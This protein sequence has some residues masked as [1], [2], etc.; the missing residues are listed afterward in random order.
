MEKK[1]KPAP[2]VSPGD[3][4][5]L[6]HNDA[7]FRKLIENSYA[8]ITLLSKDFK[9]IYRSRSAER[10]SGWSN[11]ERL[12]T[13]M[14]DLTHPDDRKMLNRHLKQSLA[15]PGAAIHCTYRSKHYNGHYIWLECS[16]T[17]M[18]NEQDVNAIVFNYHDVT[19][20]K[21]YEEK[22]Q[23]SVKELSAYKY[24]LDESAIVAITD[25]KGIIKHVNDNFCKISKYDR[26]ELLGQDH[27][28]INSSYHNK[29]FIKNIWTTIANG[30]TWKGELKNKAKDGSYYW[31][32]TT[33]VPF[34]NDQGKPYEYI[35]IRSDITERKLNQEK[36][37]EHS[38]FISTITDNIPA[39]IAYWTLDLHCLFAN[40]AL[41]DWFEMRPEEMLGIHKQALMTDNE[42]ETYAPY[43]AN[44]LH[45][46][47]QS[48]ERTFTKASGRKT[49]THTQY[50]PDKDANGDVKGFYSVIY[51]ITEVKLAELEIKKQTEQVEYLLESITDGFIGLNKN[52]CYT[53]ANKEVGKILGVD[54]DTLIG[55]YI[56]DVFPDAIGSATYNAI[57]KAFTERVYVSNEDFYEPLNLWQ[58]NRIYPTGEG[59]S[60]FIRDITKKKQ[61]EQHLKLLE[62]VIT[63]A[64]D[65]VIITEAHPLD[66]PGPR[67][68]Y[69]NDAFTKMTNYSFE[70]VNGE[71]PRILQGPKSDENELKRLSHAIRNNEHCEVTTVNYKKTGEEF[72]INFSVSP[73]KNQQGKTTHYISIE[74]D[75]TEIKNEA[76]QKAQL[77]EAVT[78]SLQERNTILESI[79][80]AFFAVDNNWMVTYWNKVAES[81][82]IKTKN[83]VLN[84]NLWDVFPTTINSKSYIEYHNAI[85][86]KKAT[87]FEDYYDQL[88][89][90]YEISAYPAA[91]GLSVYFKDITDR[92]L[93]EIMLQS[94]KKKYSELFN[95]SPLPMFLFDQYS[96]AFLDVNEAA[97]KNYGYSQTDFLSMTL[98]DIRPA[99]DLELLEEVID[100]N[101]KENFAHLGVY[102]HKKKNGDIIQVDVTTNTIA[103]KGM[104]AK[105]AVVNDV[106]QRTLYIKAIEDQNEKLREISWIQSHVV[107]APLSRILGLIPLT[108]DVRENSE[109][110]STML[111]YLSASAHELDNVIKNI[112]DK[113]TSADYNVKDQY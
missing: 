83:E 10:I 50:L 73:V 58:E 91:T 13:T 75:I 2:P 80:D 19:Q 108:N 39:M 99:E 57:Q 76:L 27:R 74:R 25:Q 61:E 56:W 104:Q 107:R 3:E 62:S 49:F 7:L 9:V 98:R 40:K 5:H 70:E 96:L 38:R 71:T 33:I 102:R 72:W 101:R 1:I 28:I 52:L 46:R 8:G 81:V 31:V 110:R 47:R 106:T 68:V 54:P 22:L 87:H 42:F 12:K 103:Y 43:I 37:A 41:L 69:V 44:V 20:Q 6:F 93:S 113:T 18:L 63:H 36:V 109:E 86:T 48:F 26:N 21:I 89:K 65:A 30:R 55:R 88:N 67:I 29:H 97:V 45:G 60:I 64:N 15:N 14:E 112:T 23:Q 51:D 17:N 78:A 85:K 111:E 32:D 59:L 84:K 79:G 35:A 77:A 4:Q 66:E 105:V 90:W 94:S 11:E 34:L 95:L 53:Y 16:F 24:A 100:K 82:L 92:K